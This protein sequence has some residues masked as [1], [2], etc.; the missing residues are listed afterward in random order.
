VIRSRDSLTVDQRAV[1]LAFADFLDELQR[2][3]D[4]GEDPPTDYRMAFTEWWL[5]MSVRYVREAK[6]W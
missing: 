5:T 3:S 2:R 4:L 1:L 6:S